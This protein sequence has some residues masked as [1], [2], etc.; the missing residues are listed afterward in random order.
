MARYQ[1]TRTWTYTTTV[2]ADSPDDALNY[3]SLED[4]FMEAYTQGDGEHRDIAVEDREPPER[5]PDDP[6]PDLR[7]EQYEAWRAK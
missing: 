3:G 6:G 5:E 1:V 4:L 7:A 2:P